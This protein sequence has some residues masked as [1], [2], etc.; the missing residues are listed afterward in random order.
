MCST[1]YYR[2]FRVCHE[3]YRDRYQ[4]LGRTIGGRKLKII[5][6][7][8][9][10]G[11]LENYRMGNMKKSTTR[12]S[13]KEIDE[14]VRAQADDDSAWEKPV[15]VRRSKSAAVSIPAEVAS[16]ACIENQ[17]LRESNSRKSGANSPFACA[18][19]TTF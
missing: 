9:A 17:P 8:N 2:R 4:L 14:L 13:E 5:A 18:L 16:R 12:K 3:G 11:L 1:L 10:D 7:L 19:K 15:Q 6:Q